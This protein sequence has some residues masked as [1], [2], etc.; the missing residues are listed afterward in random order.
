MKPPRVFAVF[1]ILFFTTMLAAESAPDTQE[2]AGRLA[3]SI[4]TGPAMS[5]LRELTDSFGGRLSGS[6]AYNHA[7]E[8]AAAKFRS[9][10]IE[11]VRLEPFIIPNGWV[12]GSA[13]GEMLAP[14]ARPLYLESLGWSPS[15]PAGGLK[16]D[17]VIVD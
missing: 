9:F 1:L 13:H 3:G 14:L 17:V 4:Y 7:V 11:N 5:T 2:T 6:P 10:G 16:G 8:W 15:T 12:R